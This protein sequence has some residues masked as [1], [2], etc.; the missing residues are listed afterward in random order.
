MGGRWL[1]S[2]GGV[3]GGETLRPSGAMAHHEHIGDN[4]VVVPEL[5]ELRMDYLSSCGRQGR[6]CVSSGTRCLTKTNRTCYSIFHATKAQNMFFHIPCGMCP[7][8]FLP[9]GIK[10]LLI[11]PS[12]CQKG[13]CPQYFLPYGIKYFLIASSPCQKGMCPQY[14]LPYGIKYHA[15]FL[16]SF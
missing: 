10:F 9:Y 12:P 6:Y 5:R 1:R 4:R 3:R 8:S 11:A 2:G 16:L 7:Q 13:M 14:F 15:M